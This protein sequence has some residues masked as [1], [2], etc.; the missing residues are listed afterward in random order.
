MGWDDYEARLPQDRV[1]FVRSLFARIEQAI[2]ERGLGW[3]PVLRST[4]FSFQRPGG[5]QCV[6]ADIRRE[7]PVEFWIKLPLTPE[8]L[9]LLGH[10]VPDIYPELEGRWDAAH[11]QWR[12]AIP[13]TEA[14]P[15]IA[16][17][18]DL[19]SHYQPPNGP[20]PTPASDS[21]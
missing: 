11:K 6:G 16:L 21:R 3:M 1:T 19:T 20:M 8:E 12:W 13:G 4:Y 5:Y 9:R 18:I 14:I 10:N 15:D 2:R 17:A 7:V